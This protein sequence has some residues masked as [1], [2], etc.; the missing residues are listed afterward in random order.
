M[1]DQA[2]RSQQQQQSN[3]AAAPSSEPAPVIIQAPQKQQPA[4]VI[5][6]PMAVNMDK[7]L[8]LS[9]EQMM[10]AQEM[11]KNSNK[12]SRPEKALILG[13]MAGS[14]DNPCPDL[15]NVVTIKL[16]ENE[17]TVTQ[18]DGVS[19]RCMVETHYQMNYVTGEG[20]RIKKYLRIDAPMHQNVH[21]GMQQQQHPQQ[22]V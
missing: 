7:K 20:K 1:A 5:M 22:P 10:E 21:T 18:T 12:V 6:S 4:H 8:V 13:F 9:K 15:G 19:V 14:R 11:F 2:V 17:E 16:N 3:T